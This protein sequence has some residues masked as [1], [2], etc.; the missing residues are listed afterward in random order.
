MCHSKPGKDGGFDMSKPFSGG[1]E[2]ELPPMFGTGKLVAANI[3][4]DKDTGIGKWTEEQI[5]NAIKTMSRP[6]GSI[7]QGPMQFYLAGWSKL[8]EKDL[9]AIAAYV[10]SIPADKNKVAKS[11][12]KPAGPPPGAGGGGAAGSA[13]GSG[14]GSAAGSAAK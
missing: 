9:K 5:A 4:S 11:T 6:D 10:K 14:A 12:F 7:I 13:A 3:T 2:F 8:E 1:M